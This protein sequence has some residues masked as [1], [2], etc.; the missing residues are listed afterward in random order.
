MYRITFILFVILYLI[1]VNNS[2]AVSIA[3]DSNT[4]LRFMCNVTIELYYCKVYIESSTALNN[5]PVFWYVDGLHAH[6]TSKT[7][8]K[9]ITSHIRGSKKSKYLVTTSTLKTDRVKLCV[10][11]NC[12]RLNKNVDKLY[13]LR[14]ILYI[15]ISQLL[16]QILIP[17]IKVIV[18]RITSY[19][20]LNILVPSSRQTD[21][22]YISPPSLHS[23]T[24]IQNEYLIPVN[25]SYVNH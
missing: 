15:I 8:V 13:E 24:S 23:Y 3:S 17:I 5:V 9:N 20:K 4:E 6:I 21:S 1:T 11:Q 10:L 12:V 7:R 14:I 25:N 22:V 19:N 2:I 18:K 16:L